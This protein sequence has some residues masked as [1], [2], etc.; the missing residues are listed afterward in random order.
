MREIICY[1]FVF[2]TVQPL[3]WH[4]CNIISVTKMFQGVGRPLM[5]NIDLDGICDLMIALS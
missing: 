2:S 1:I 5:G 4:F 3:V